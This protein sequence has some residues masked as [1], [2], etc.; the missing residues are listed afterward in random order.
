MSELWNILRRKL[1]FSSITS[2]ICRLCWNVFTF[3]HEVLRS[4]SWIYFSRDWKNGRLG[5]EIYIAVYIN[6]V[7]SCNI[8]LIRIDQFSSS[9]MGNFLSLM[10]ISLSSNCYTLFL[11]VYNH[12]V[13]AC[14]SYKVK[15]KQALDSLMTTH[16]QHSWEACSR[17]SIIRSWQHTNIFV[18][19]SPEVDVWCGVPVHGNSVIRLLGAFRGLVLRRVTY[20]PSVLGMACWPTCN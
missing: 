9:H 17:V 18:K 19:T 3:S 8:F 11:T 6:Y 12:K 10:N 5:H 20:K 15:A 16:C 13:H 2:Q 1:I 4:I 14:I 7:G